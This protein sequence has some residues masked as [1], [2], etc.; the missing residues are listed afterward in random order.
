MKYPKLFEPGKIGRLDIKNRVV[1]TPA[2]FA[3]GDSAGGVGEQLFDYLEE[4]AKGGAGIVMRRSGRYQNRTRQSNRSGSGES[5]SV[6]D[7]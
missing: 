7:L 4:R 5:L 3:W 6:H 1:V 2:G